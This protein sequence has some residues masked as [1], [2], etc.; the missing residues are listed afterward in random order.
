MLISRW[1]SKWRASVIPA[2]AFG[3][4]QPG[5]VVYRVKHLFTTRDGSWDPSDKDGSLPQWARDTYLKPM[6]DPQYN[7]D[8]GADH[9]LFGAVE[10]GGRLVPALKFGYWTG[11]NQH[12]SERYAKRHGWANIPIWNIFYP[13]QGSGGAWLWSPSGVACDVVSGG[14]M[15]Y[16]LHVSWWAVW[17]AEAV[18]GETQPEQKP[19]EKPGLTRA[20]LDQL[21]R[22][23]ASVRAKIEV[24]AQ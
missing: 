18:Q 20:D 7:D 10:Q 6:S 21:D 23:W 8:G 15:P 13:D 16:G 1:A 9:N 19:E 14:G 2:E 4:L 12:R 11:D 5:D 22:S 3:P 17:T 24:M